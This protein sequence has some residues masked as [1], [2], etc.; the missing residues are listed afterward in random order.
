MFTS[1]QGTVAAWIALYAQNIAMGLFPIVLYGGFRSTS[2][3]SHKTADS[4]LI[5]L[6]FGLGAIASMNYPIRTPEGLSIDA[7]IVFVL[8]GSLYGRPLGAALA[9]ALAVAYRIEIGGPAALSG[10][11]AIVTAGAVGL[12]FGR[13]RAARLSDLGFFELALIGLACSV[14]TAIVLQ[15]ALMLSGVPAMSLTSSAA[16]FVVFPLG[17]AVLG[18]ALSMTRNRVLWRVQQRLADIVETTSDLVWETDAEERMTFVSE[19]HRAVFGFPLERYSGKRPSELGSRW[20]DEA[21]RAAHDA[22]LAA[23]EPFFH[24]RATAITET[25]DRRFLSISGRP[26][27]DD[28]GRFTG[29]RGTATDITDQVRLDLELRR[30]VFRLERAQRIGKIGYAETDLATGESVWSDDI[31]RNLGLDPAG[32]ASFDRYLLRVHPDDQDRV[33]S[34]RDKN[35]KGQAIEPSEYRILRPD[36]SIV[37]VRREVEV[38]RDAKGNAV[39]LFT[40]EQDI[41][42]HKEMELE[43]ARLASTD[44]LTGVFNRR[45]L[46][47]LGER[48]LARVR[49]GREAAAVIMLDLDHFKSVNDRFGHSVGDVV[50]RRVAEVCQRELRPEDVFGRMGGEEFVAICPGCDHVTARQ[51]AERLMECLSTAEIDCGGAPLRATASFGISDLVAGDPD[52]T[53]ALD[54]ADRALYEAKAAGRN[55]VVERWAEHKFWPLDRPADRG[56]DRAVERRHAPAPGPGKR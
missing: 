20:I 53:A 29:Y 8:V 37:W 12:V 33:R 28:H 6:L 3:G 25:G 47:E 24:L 46:L 23:R 13:I 30:T 40:T 2:L 14:A 41:T 27:F 38:V 56:G 36:G 16:G 32:G 39:H 31:Y 26:V 54:R 48:Q 10:S 7:R 35:V 21:T 5:G 52:M 9:T 15:L 45:R 42:E 19:R 22:A 4:L 11:A 18:L 44:P 43:L 17:T 1:Q 55:R 51:V 50:L 49:R 34:I